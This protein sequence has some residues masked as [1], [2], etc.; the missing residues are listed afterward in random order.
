VPS[1][2]SRATAASASPIVTDPGFQGDIAESSAG[3]VAEERIGAVIDHV[4]IEPAVVVVIRP[5]YA[6]ARHIR[7]TQIIREFGD[8][9]TAI[10]IV[11][12]EYIG[13]EVAGD[14]EIDP[15]VAIIIAPSLPDRQIALQRFF[16][17]P[18]AAVRRRDAGFGADIA[19]KRRFLRL[20][21]SDS[22]G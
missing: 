16:I 9:K 3:F 18:D 7:Q 20:R 5:E 2:S 8:R 22:R 12:I 14:I 6:S 1:F 21:P 15:A 11:A 4:E 17:V 19:E 13:I 10:L